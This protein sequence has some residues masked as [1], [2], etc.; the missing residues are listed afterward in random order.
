MAQLGEHAG[1]AA[2]QAP[3]L[4][5]GDEGF[6]VPVRA[7][8]PRPNATQPVTRT[9][10]GAWL[11]PRDPLQTVGRW[12]GGWDRLLHWNALATIEATAARM[13]SRS[14]FVLA[15]TTI[16]VKIKKGTN[17]VDP[18]LQLGHSGV[19]FF[20][21]R[22]TCQQTNHYWRRPGCRTA[23]L[24]LPK[25]QAVNCAPR[26]QVR[27]KSAKE[28]QMLRYGTRCGCHALPRESGIVIYD[29]FTISPQAPSEL[30]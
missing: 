2:F 19:G 20:P 30:N 11:R 10:T 21:Q 25:I 15:G 9:R 18:R 28:Q 3:A 24:D 12:G 26:E 8:A 16:P 1:L 14:F 6:A 29:P 23:R 7:R 22:R 4:R 5:N 13:P 27:Q 17:R